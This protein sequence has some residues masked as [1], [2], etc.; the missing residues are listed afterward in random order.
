MVGKCV[1]MVLLS[2]DDQIYY[3]IVSSI[4]LCP[5]PWI[6][7]YDSPQMNGDLGYVISQTGQNVI[8]KEPTKRATGLDGLNVVKMLMCNVYTYNFK[9][10]LFIY[11]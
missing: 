9:I 3:T 5:T 4:M 6:P 2:P 10:I 8:M 1:W 11:S 7:W